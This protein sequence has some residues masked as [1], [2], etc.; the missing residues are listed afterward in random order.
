MVQRGL[1]SNRS[2][3]LHLAWRM[4]LML[5][6]LLCLLAFSSTSDAQSEVEPRSP[7]QTLS[8]LERPD[9]PPRYPQRD[10]L[11]HRSGAMRVLLRFTRPDA[12]PDVEVL[13]NTARE[14]MQDEAYRYLRGYR[15]PCLSADDG[16]VKAVQEFSFSNSDRP[17]TPLP[18]ETSARGPARCLV[19]PRKDAK[20]H[21]GYSSVG[22]EHLLVE[23]TFAGDGDSP[24]SVKQLFTTGDSRLEKSVREQLELYR[25]PCRQAGDRPQKFT[26]LFSLHPK[27]VRRFGFQR[28]VYDLPAFL[29]MTRDTP[30]RA[31][32]FDFTSMACP[33]KVDYLVWG[34]G[35]P[36]EA[37]VAGPLN[38]NRQPFL[39][40]LAKLELDTKSDKQALDLF[41]SRLQIEIPCTDMDLRE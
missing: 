6:V 11:D 14:D 5:S 26:Q 34:Q 37:H 1:Q 8:C 18:P 41:G 38:P 35:L 31:A 29:A 28:Q 16:V 19:V 2:P 24:P 20:V 33:F 22:V 7:A 23:I 39:A 21:L 36:N 32:Y 13:L 12:A 9:R 4:N 40:W 25:M 17:P 30:T 10:R 3:G 27:G 15:L